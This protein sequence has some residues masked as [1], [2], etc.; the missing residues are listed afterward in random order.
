MGSWLVEGMRH[1]AGER[2][3]GWEWLGTSTMCS[4]PAAP[5]LLHEG[6]HS[7]GWEGC[8]TLQQDGSTT[9]HSCGM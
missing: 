4:I 2:G 8:A 6:L 3:A 1:Y 7:F 9:G 5:H